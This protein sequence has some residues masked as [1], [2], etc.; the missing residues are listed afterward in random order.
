[1]LNAAYFSAPVITQTAG[2]AYTI[3]RCS[4]VYIAGPP[5]AGAGGGATPVLTATGVASLVVASGATH[6]P[7]GSVGSPAIAFGTDAVAGLYHTGTGATGAVLASVNGVNGWTLTTTGLG[8]GPNGTLIPRA[9]IHVCGNRAIGAP[10]GLREVAIFNGGGKVIGDG[11]LI[12]LMGYANDIDVTYPTWRHAQIGAMYTAAGAGGWS[13]D[14]LFRVNVGTS[15]TSLIET[16]RITGA[17]RLVGINTAVPAA[18]LD[19]L[20]M[21]GTTGLPQASGMT[22]AAHTGMTAGSE[23]IGARFN[24]SATKTWA[25]GAIATQRE[26][27]IEAPTYAFA[28]ASTITT[29]ATLAISGP[30]IAGANATIT[31]PLALWIQSGNLALGSAYPTT[32]MLAGTSATSNAVIQATNGNLL[33]FNGAGWPIVLINGRIGLTSSP[34]LAGA[35]R[36]HL[37]A[38]F[39]QAAAAG[40]TWD[41]VHFAAS[42]LTL[43]GATTPVTTL[44]FV[45]IAAP[46]ITAASAV[47]TTDFYTCRIGKATFTGAGPASATRQWALGLDDNLQVNSGNIVLGTGVLAGTSANLVLAMH[48]GATAPSSAVNLAQLYC[49]DIAADRAT[50]AVY[51]EEAVAADVGLASTHSFIVFLNGAKYKLMLVSVP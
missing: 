39:T 18:T 11:P 45:T 38:S 14:L 17:T 26:F 51:S 46:T 43:S 41:G 30:P 10:A 8:V 5:T 3:P 7:D 35:T 33:T 6:F 31:N 27:A 22:T 23:D 50:L 25:T 34:S 13:G 1:M 20:Q 44:N 29:A 21:A 42:T 16:M 12:S 2:A 24:F 28:A 9:A 4:T 15:Q 40:T 49:A 32:L 47:V 36:L 19:I 37:S 48:N